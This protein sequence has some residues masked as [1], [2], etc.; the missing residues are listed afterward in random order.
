MQRFQFN[1]IFTD[2]TSFLD[3]VLSIDLYSNMQALSA[4]CYLELMLLPLELLFSDCV[5][6]NF[7]NRSLHFM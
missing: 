6:N 5:K 4:S 3:M 2:V 7:F 1:T